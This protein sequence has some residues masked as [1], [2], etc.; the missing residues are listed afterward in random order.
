M[1]LEVFII[2]TIYFIIIK[3]KSFHLEKLFKDFFNLYQD[4]IKMII[5]QNFTNYLKDNNENQNNF[6]HANYDAFVTWCSY[7]YMINEYGLNY[8]N[9]LNFVSCIY[10]G[11]KEKMN[12]KIMLIYIML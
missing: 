10:K 9:K 4:K 7:I 3:K 8:I 6:H 2:Q 11:I 5:P 1:N 12:W